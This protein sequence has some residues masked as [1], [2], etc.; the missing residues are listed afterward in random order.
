MIEASFREK[1]NMALRV[2]V[3]DYGKEWGDHCPVSLAWGNCTVFNDPKACK[4]CWATYIT[5]LCNKGGGRDGQVDRFPATAS[6][7]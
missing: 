6:R 4:K 2:I 7:H 5:D 1:F 3:E